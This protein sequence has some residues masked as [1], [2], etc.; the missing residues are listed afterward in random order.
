MSLRPWRSPWLWIALAATALLLFQTVRVG[1]VGQDTYP[2]L[3]SCRVRT[4]ADVAELFGERLMGGTHNLY[5]PLFNVTIAVDERLFGLWSPGYQITNALFFALCA[6]ASGLLAG[7]LLGPAAR[8]APFVAT[9]AFAL[10][11]AH[12]E[13]LPVIARRPDTMV[14]AF[15]CLALWSQLSERSLS[16]SRPPWT[17]A[18]L[19]LLAMG[20]KDGGLLIAPL[21]FLA[22]TL[23]SPRATLAARARHALVA[24]IPHAVLTT[25]F[26]LARSTV[27]AGLGGMQ[28]RDTFAQ[29]L[30]YPAEVGGMLSVLLTPE[31]V[32]TPSWLTAGLTAA[33][34]SVVLCATLAGTRGTRGKR[35]ETSLAGQTA[36][37]AGAWL[38]LLTAM[39][40]TREV[41]REWYVFQLLAPWVLLL[42]AAA[43]HLLALA[44]SSRGTLR[45]LAVVGLGLLGAMLTWNA[46]TSPLFHRYHEWS[47]QTADLDAFY[48]ELG[49]RIEGSTPPALVETPPFPPHHGVPPADRPYVQVMRNVRRNAIRAWVELTSP[50]TRVRTAH[51]SQ[52]KLRPKDELVLVSEEFPQRERPGKEDD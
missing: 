30:N 27:V 34:G 24:V 52:A 42:A 3:A 5:R 49:R 31:R 50:G 15:C 2:I 43:E 17:P 13:V 22:V 23:Y 12:F 21:C 6:A 40:A 20:S 11:P 48:A 44:R 10:F 41:W 14:Y 33:C 45:V 1:F 38:L 39:Y 16:A 8:I 32:L 28:S 7:R 29:L 47:Q 4:L 35:T 37:L 19:A 36:V 26:L 51:P 25:L 18:V 9:L 46:R